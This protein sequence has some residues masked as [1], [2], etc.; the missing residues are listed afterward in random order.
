VSFFNLREH[1]DT[2]ISN[3]LNLSSTLFISKSTTNSKNLIPPRETNARTGFI[4]QKNLP[5]DTL[6]SVH[7]DWLADSNSEK[8]EAKAQSEK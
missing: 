2:S 8:E 7:F 5:R 6:S 4:N 1:P 3:F